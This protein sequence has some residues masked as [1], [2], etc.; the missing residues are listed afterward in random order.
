MEGNEK[1]QNLAGDDIRKYGEM[2]AVAQNTD[3]VF[4]LKNYDVL[5]LSSH[6]HTQG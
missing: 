1:R 6:N 2:L 5:T 4:N 3:T